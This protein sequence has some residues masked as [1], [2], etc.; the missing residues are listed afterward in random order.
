MSNHQNDDDDE[1]PSSFA[2]P[3]C[4]MHE[5]DP[6]YSGLPRPVDDRRQVDDAAVSRPPDVNRPNIRKKR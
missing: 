4:F 5:L 2:S 3:P 6:I 1:P